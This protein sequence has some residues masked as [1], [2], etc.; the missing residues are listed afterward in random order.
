[1]L[2]VKATK[3][4]VNVTYMNFQKMQTFYSKEFTQV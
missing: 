1:M 4:S 3:R 2:Q